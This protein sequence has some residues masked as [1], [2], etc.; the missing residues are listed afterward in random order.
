MVWLRAFPMDMLK[1]KTNS[2]IAH[3]HKK[4]LP[5]NMLHVR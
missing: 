3:N 5:T 4:G 1:G 2:N